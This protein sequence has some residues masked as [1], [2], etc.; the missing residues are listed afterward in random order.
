[1]AAAKSQSKVGRARA[2][3]MPL[4]RTHELNYCQDLDTQTPES[5]K[6]LGGRARKAAGDEQARNISNRRAWRFPPEDRSDQP[7]HSLPVLFVSF[8]CAPDG[9]RGICA[10]VSSMK[11]LTFHTPKL[12][13]V[14]QL[15]CR[16]KSLKLSN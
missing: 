4:I 9:R 10:G 13:T 14:G 3:K 8:L 1:L 11:R 5:A 12:V 7:G 2:R 16:Q 6:R 15:N